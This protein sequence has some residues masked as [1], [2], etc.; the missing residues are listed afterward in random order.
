MSSLCNRREV[1]LV[2]T[3][4]R[5]MFS[6]ISHTAR[7]RSS[8][9]D[10]H[11]A[12][13]PKKDP[14]TLSSL[15][16]AGDAHLSIASQHARRGR[17]KRG[18]SAGNFPAF[19]YVITIRR[20]HHERTRRSHTHTNQPAQGTHLALD[21]RVRA[22]AGVRSPAQQVDRAPSAEAPHSLRDPLDS[23]CATNL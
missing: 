3:A 5:P 18:E 4:A 17:W 23:A 6:A 2:E 1:K 14:S 13:C 7:K 20:N 10:D 8:R 16:I 15:S 12:A 11:R 19:S 21:Q 22:R 9:V